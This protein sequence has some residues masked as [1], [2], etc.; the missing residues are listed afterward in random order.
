[1]LVWKE[2]GT[3]RLRRQD[4]NVVSVT[5]AGEKGKG[6]YNLRGLKFVLFEYEESLRKAAKQRRRRSCG[7]TFM[8]LET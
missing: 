6:F 1:M 2:P 5:F 3:A 7:K 4:F 8:E